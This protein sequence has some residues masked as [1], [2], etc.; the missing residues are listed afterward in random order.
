MC[1]WSAFLSPLA[2]LSVVSTR[3]GGNCQLQRLTS[4]YAVFNAVLVVRTTD[5]QEFQ[6]PGVNVLEMIARSL[7]ISLEYVLMV[8]LSVAL[9]PSLYVL[10]ETIDFGV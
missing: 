7:S 2:S 8:S 3:V 10:V 1:L 5:R 9:D 6:I 4:V